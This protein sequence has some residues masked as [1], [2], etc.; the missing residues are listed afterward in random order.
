MLGGRDIE[1]KIVA[2]VDVYSIATNTWKT[3]Q[4]LLLPENLFTSDGTAFA[5]E[6]VVYYL[7]FSSRI[8]C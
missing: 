5:H 2:H 3:D 4:G 1:D 6:G 7:G 8:N